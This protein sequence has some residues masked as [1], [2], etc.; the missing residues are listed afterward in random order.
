MFANALNLGLKSVVN[1]SVTT[2]K[3]TKIGGNLMSILL[4]WKLRFEC[5]RGNTR[6]TKIA[7]IWIELGTFYFC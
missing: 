3:K 6:N 1:R 4:D 7:P 5:R 2:I